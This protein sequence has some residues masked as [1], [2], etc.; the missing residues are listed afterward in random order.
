MKNICKAVIAATILMASCLS[1]AQ[2]ISTA[3]L[4]FAGQSVLSGVENF[5][6]PTSTEPAIVWG[7]VPGLEVLYK[8]PENFVAY[9]LSGG[10][11]VSDSL[12][13]VPAIP[14][15]SAP[16]PINAPFDGI[17][18]PVETPSPEEIVNG[19]LNLIAGGIPPR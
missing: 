15:V 5:Q 18:V 14:F 19:M 10:T 17:S 6:F 2:I 9:E 7:F 13:M 3:G 1:K 8:E 4:E 12:V 11:V 16:M